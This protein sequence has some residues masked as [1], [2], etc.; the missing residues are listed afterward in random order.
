MSRGIRQRRG[1]NF[2]R[3]SYMDWQEKGKGI[4]LTRRGLRDEGVKGLRGK[5][6]MGIFKLS[7]E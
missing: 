7:N 2:I 3:D 1:V 4:S 5:K 6:S